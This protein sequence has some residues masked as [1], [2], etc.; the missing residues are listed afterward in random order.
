[1]GLKYPVVY[2]FLQADSPMGFN[3]GGFLLPRFVCEKVDS[4]GGATRL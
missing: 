2:F 1:M 4:F 3:T